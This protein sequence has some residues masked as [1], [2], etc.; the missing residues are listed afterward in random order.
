MGEGRGCAVGPTRARSL[1]LDASTRRW[2][3][4]RSPVRGAVTSAPTT[5]VQSANWS[6]VGSTETNN[7]MRVD[8]SIR[9]AKTTVK[10]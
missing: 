10:G 6:A 7:R 5:N 2:L 3:A 4:G 1:L 8:S 9:E